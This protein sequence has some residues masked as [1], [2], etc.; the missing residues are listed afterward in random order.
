MSIENMNNAASEIRS[1]HSSDLKNFDPD[2]RLDISET[3]EKN[4]NKIDVFDPDKRI[5][6]TDI[7][8]GKYADLKKADNL[9]EKEIHHTPADSANH[10]DTKEGPAIIMDKADHMQTAS[11]GNSKEARISGET[12][13]TC[14]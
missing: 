13:K 12:G 6:K 9:D 1:A 10:M 11:W 5:E 14:E 4:E 8:G 3:A 2:K 7:Q